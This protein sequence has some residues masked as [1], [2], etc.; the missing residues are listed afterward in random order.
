MPRPARPNLSARAEP[1]SL[2]ARLAAAEERARRCA[3]AEHRVRQELEV[4]QEEASQQT[5]QLVEANEALEASH[6]RYVSLYDYAPVSFVSLDHNGIIDDLNLAAADLLGAE[7]DRLL[8]LP[9][10]SFVHPDTRRSFLDHMLR[11]R[12]NEVPAKAE[13]KIQ[14]RKGS[15]VP[16]LLATW[17]GVP[18]SGPGWEFRSALLDLTDRK[19][20]EAQE[21]LYQ[22]RLSSLASELS[23][24]EERERRRIAVE[25]HDNLSQN[26]ALIKMKVS[27]ISGRAQ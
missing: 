7:R 6:E 15:I 12:R 24:A 13:L 10:L 9:L 16:V 2:R 19:L 3:E 26:L 4:Y 1:K 18:R 8:K 23:L 17:F 22:K 25:I 14:T 5:Q 20:A 27:M 11:C 21:A